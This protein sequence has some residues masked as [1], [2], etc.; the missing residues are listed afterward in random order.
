MR[1]T[2]LYTLDQRLLEGIKHALKEAG[3]KSNNQTAV[4]AAVEFAAMSIEEKFK[5]KK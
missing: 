1:K 4:A 5:N 3:E 2:R